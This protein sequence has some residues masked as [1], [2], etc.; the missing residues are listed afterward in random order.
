MRVHSNS[1]QYLGTR[2]LQQDNFYF[3]DDYGIAIVSDGIGSNMD[4]GLFSGELVAALA[5]RLKI[6]SFQDFQ[7]IEVFKNFSKEFLLRHANI[8][9][10]KNL[11]ATLA[12]CK[13][14]ENY[15]EVGHIGDSKIYIFKN[16]ALIYESRDH[17][18]FNELENQL[19]DDDLISIKPQ[20]IHQLTRAILVNTQDSELEYRKIEFSNEDELCILLCTDGVTP[21]VGQCLQKE[22]KLDSGFFDHLNN[23]CEK[24]ASDNAT[25]V[26]TYLEIENK[27]KINLSNFMFYL[28]IVS[29]VFIGIL[30]AYYSI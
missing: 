26:I 10:Y 11:G 16:K 2:T 25:A 24:E 15:V 12:L 17:T 19:E 22:L 18:L 23:I 21:F 30:F 20:I 14:T 29:F 6:N 28:I 27:P 5:G 9:D 4:S 3:D 7:F 8:S 13:I 1:F